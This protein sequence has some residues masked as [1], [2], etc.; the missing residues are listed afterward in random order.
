TSPLPPPKGLSST[1]QG[2]AALAGIARSAW[3]EPKKLATRIQKWQASWPDHPANELIGQILA[4][5]QRS[6]QY[7]VKIALLLP[8]TGAYADQARAVEDGLLAAYYRG[9]EPR[10]TVAIYDT[11]GSAQGARAAFAK[12]RAGAANFVVGPLVPTGVNAVA[13]MRPAVPVLALNYLNAGTR[14]PAH[15][16]QFGLSPSQEARSAAERA[17]ARGLE[18]AVVLVPANGW[19]QRIGQ[20]FTQRFEQLGGTVISSAVFQPGAVHFAAPLTALLGGA[21]AQAPAGATASGSVSTLASKSVP[22]GPQ[23]V[24]FAASSFDTAQLIVPQIAYYGGIGLP[25]YSISSVYQPGASANDLDGVN[26]PVMPWFVDSEASIAGLRQMLKTLYPN[27]WRNYA[28]L[29]AL[30]YDAWRLIPLLGFNVNQPLAQPVLGVTG[31]LGLNANNVIKR[32]AEWAQYVN[33]KPRVAKP[34]VPGSIV[35]PA[36]ATR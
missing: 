15:F 5:A 17:F 30:G 1:A 16:F 23:F 14:A 36:P 25:V 10:P 4:Q 34:P 33:G 27:R 3:L 12:A 21:P 20:A 18:R 8:L 7:P 11:R 28:T 2:W 22:G 32:R 29:Y 26:F 13:A 31:T 9:T 6:G 35:S 24:F 19:G